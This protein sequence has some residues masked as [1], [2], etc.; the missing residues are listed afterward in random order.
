M[1]DQNFTMQPE[2]FCFWRNDGTRKSFPRPLPF[3]SWLNGSK[4]SMK[5][6]MA[7]L[8]AATTRYYKHIT[9]KSRKEGKGTK[10]VHLRSHSRR[11]CKAHCKIQQHMAVSKLH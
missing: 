4:G 2:A 7:T 9:T 1:R 5:E 11:E 3:P 8:E 10:S 6:S